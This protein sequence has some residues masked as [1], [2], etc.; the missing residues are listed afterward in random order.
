ML[1]IPSSC[2]KLS[3][4]LG[5]P[6]LERDVL[7]GRPLIRCFPKYSADPYGSVRRMQGFREARAGPDKAKFKGGPF[8]PSQ[9]FIVIVIVIVIVNTTSY[10]APLVAIHF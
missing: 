6:P 5:P 9:F 4:L 1:F 10:I 7:Y 2:H 3:H 8:F